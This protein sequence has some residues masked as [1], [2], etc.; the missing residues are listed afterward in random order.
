MWPATSRGTTTPGSAWVDWVVTDFY[1][2][3][4]NFAGLRRLLAGPRFPA[5]PPEIP[6]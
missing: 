3:F 6:G 4:P 2:K 1:G 5:F